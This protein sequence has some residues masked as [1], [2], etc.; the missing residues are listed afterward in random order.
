MF[1]FKIAL[2]F[3]LSNKTQTI[4][5]ALGIA[6]G[7]SVQVFIGSLIQG[8]Q[9]SLIDSTIGN[10][11][12]ITI[13]AETRGGYL[14]DDDSFYQTLKTY[15]E[16][17][18]AVSPVL[19]G[20][21][22]VITEDFNDP[23]IIRGFNYDDANDIYQFSD[24][25]IEGRLPTS[26]NEVV[27]GIDLLENLNA[28]IDDTLELQLPEADSLKTVTIVGVFDFE[29]TSINT[30]WL[31]MELDSAQSFLA[32]DGISAIE[33]QLDSVFNS[34][35]IQENLLDEYGNDYTITEWQGANQELLTGLEGQSTSSI[36]IQVFVMISV[37]LGISSVLAITVL[38]KSKQLGILKA[39]G[40]TDKQASFIFLF[41]GILLGLIGAVLGVLLGL[42]LLF[43]F[44]QSTDV[45]PILINP[46]F[47]T[48]SAIIAILASMVAS[49]IP[50]RRSAKLSV[51]EVIR[52][53]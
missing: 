45:V 43:G 12:H 49:L 29:V 40:A 51:I 3:L 27:I 37:V 21:A 8:L 34:V 5:I 10:R 19:E 38:Q 32:V 46:L 22:T 39:M 17:I 16:D 24:K 20:S 11:S 9:A 41:E 53:G 25:V 48:G 35:S 7:V 13:T 47:I 6:V 2:R 33:M 28:S 15:D 18:T 14:D 42:G 23:V 1:S 30:S 31:L 44:T 36:M 4:L 52:N 50:A 26:A